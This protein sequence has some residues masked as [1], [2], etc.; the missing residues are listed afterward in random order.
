MRYQASPDYNYVHDPHQQ[1][2]YLVR[3]N[4]GCNIINEDALI[5]LLEKQDFLVNNHRYSD[6]FKTACQLGWLVTIPPK[7]SPVES[8]R[9]LV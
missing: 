2:G 1:R 8:S 6:F 5:L 3:K 4:G 9:N 7:T